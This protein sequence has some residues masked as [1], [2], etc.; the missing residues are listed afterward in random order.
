[1][2][3]AVRVIGVGHPDRGDD[4][5]GLLVARALAGRLPCSVEV[6][7]CGGDLLN[8]IEV[9]RG[10]DRVVVV[11]AMLSGLPPG[12]VHVLEP[13]SAA[14]AANLPLSNHGFGLSEAI[15]LARALDALPRRL[16]IVAI[17]GTGFEAGGGLSPEVRAA[18]DEAAEML[19]E[20][21]T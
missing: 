11:D 9:W 16:V 19:V 3:A 14:A 17:E 7:E 1:M 8:L 13:A 21:L 12:T 15:A 5:A 20:A 2:T 4:A 10:A 6:Y 18:V